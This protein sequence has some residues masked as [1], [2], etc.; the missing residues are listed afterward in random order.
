MDKKE[1][2]KDS[3]EREALSKLCEEQGVKM[4]RA[5][6]PP[7]VM[8]SRKNC[9]SG[10]SQFKGSLWAFRQVRNRVEYYKKRAEEKTGWNAL[11]KYLDIM[12]ADCVE[13]KSQ[14]QHRL[15]NALAT[16]HHSLDPDTLKSQAPGNTIGKMEKNPVKQKP[17][18]KKTMEVID[19][20]KGDMYQK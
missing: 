20:Q 5:L 15:D 3:K 4:I 1:I 17:I 14:L 8:K 12:I 2:V 19:Y 11:L 13:R 7:E 10:I 16:K 18:N 9:K 6:L